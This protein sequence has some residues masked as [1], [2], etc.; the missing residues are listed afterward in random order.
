M[1]A[2]VENEL[3]TTDLKQ[4]NRSMWW[5]WLLNQS[6]FSSWCTI[7]YPLPWA[8]VHWNTTGWSSVH[9][10]TTG[11][12]SE[13]RRVHWNTME[14]LCW[15]CPTHTGMLLE[16]LYCR[17]HWNTTWGGG[18]GLFPPPPPPPPPPPHTH[19]HTHTTH[20][21]PMPVWNDEV[22]GPQAATG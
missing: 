12:P 7:A 6:S 13:Y 18:G 5:Y 17:L 19:T 11:R 15:N 14:K 8:S 9:W 16:K 4:V 20:T 21:A 2:V 22:T 10:D 1:E 3:G